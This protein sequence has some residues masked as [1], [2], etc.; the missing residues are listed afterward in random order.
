MGRRILQEQIDESA[1]RN[2]QWKLRDV[3]ALIEELPEARRAKDQYG[4]SP[5]I[6]L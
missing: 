3:L 1:S 2:P 5:R 6:P 4:I